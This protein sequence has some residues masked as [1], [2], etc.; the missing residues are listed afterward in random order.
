MSETF[1]LYTE[2]TIEI[3]A[4]FPLGSRTHNYTKDDGLPPFLKKGILV[5]Q[6]K[7]PMPWFSDVMEVPSDI[8][9]SEGDRAYSAHQIKVGNRLGV[10]GVDPCLQANPA[11]SETLPNLYA[12]VPDSSAISFSLLN[13]RWR[14]FFSSAFMSSNSSVLVERI[15]GGTRN[16]A[17]RG[18]INR[19]QFQESITTVS[20]RPDNK[21]LDAK[22]TF[23]FEAQLKEWEPDFKIPIVSARVLPY[24]IKTVDL[25]PQRAHSYD[26]W[27][28]DFAT[29]YL[30]SLRSDPPTETDFRSLMSNRFKNVYPRYVTFDKEELIKC[31][32]TVSTEYKEVT[33]RPM[34]GHWVH[35]NRGIFILPSEDDQ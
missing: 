15:S 14:P 20:A 26:T 23:G 29:Y 1:E 35:V 17:W 8:E 27:F 13:P 9:I 19:I 2:I 3:Y 11:T 21:R 5:R 16:F 10:P 32:S 24:T 22:A 25:P 12:G 18:F 30:S 4:P 31:N 28:Y 6:N 33:V 7:A 34:Q